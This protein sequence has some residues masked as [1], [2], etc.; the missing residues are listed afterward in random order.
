MITKREMVSDQSIALTLHIL[1]FSPCPGASVSPGAFL[2]SWVP[3]VKAICLWLCGILK[4]WNSSPGVTKCGWAPSFYTGKVCNFSHTGWI[5]SSL[6]SYT[7]MIFYCLLH[8]IF[9]GLSIMD[10]AVTKGRQ[11]WFPRSGP[12]SSLTLGWYLFHIAVGTVG[13]VNV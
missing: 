11:K 12:F 7:S 4:M 5:C 13:N 6:N 10:F 9:M 1:G 8:A 2:A 3:Q